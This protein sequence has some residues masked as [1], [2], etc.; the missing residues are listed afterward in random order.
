MQIGNH[1][2]LVTGG[3]SGLGAATAR[4]FV[5]QGGSVVIADLDRIA[6]EKLAAELGSAARFALTDVT[7][8]TR[9]PGRGRLRA[10]G[11]RPSARTGQLR[12]HRAF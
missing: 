6:G 11:L 1:V 7:S 8:E 12:R 3:A 5:A 4:L 2:F 10:R 9:R